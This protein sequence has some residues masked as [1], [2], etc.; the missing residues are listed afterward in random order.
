MV[1][2]TKVAPRPRGRPQVRPD[3]ETRQLIIAAARQ[4]FHQNGYAGASMV[5]VAE[6]A[7][8]STKT[9]YRLIPTKAELFRN[10]VS[11]RISGFILE[12]DAE[13]LDALPIKDALEHI[14]TSYGRLT[15]DEDTT[16]TF[17]LVLA[18]SDR[19]PGLAA[20]FAAL[21]IR[22]TTE[23]MEAWLARQRDRGLIE[24]EDPHAAIGMLRGMM[25]MEPQR[26]MMLGVSGPPD[27]AEIAERA[28]C[29]ARLFLEGCRRQRKR[30]S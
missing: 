1:D 22:R 19:F 15:L 27:D 8:V 21:A 4:E 2:N 16:F 12:M 26:A 14:L 7:G 25:I 28:R 13:S 23:T 3:A 24:V 29:C 6:R 9:M 11:D 5:R 18:E 10:V 20:D 30:G 17:R